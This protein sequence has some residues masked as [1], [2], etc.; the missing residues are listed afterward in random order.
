MALAMKEQS[1]KV[2]LLVSLPFYFGGVEE[3]LCKPPKKG[4][5]LA[6]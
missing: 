1:H 5:L 4:F 2:G 3:M 6:A